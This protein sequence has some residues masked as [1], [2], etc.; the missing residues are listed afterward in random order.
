MILGTQNKRV[1]C[2]TE[3]AP[4]QYSNDGMECLS[5]RPSVLFMGAN[6]LRFRRLAQHTRT[7]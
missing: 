7:R 1:F 4:I 2:A 5:A 3:E 6:H